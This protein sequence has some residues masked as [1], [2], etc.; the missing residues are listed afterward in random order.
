MSEGTNPRETA[1]PLWAEVDG[2][3]THHLVG[4]DAVGEAI[5]ATNEREGLGFGAVAPSEGKLLELL[6]R[7]HGARKILEVGTHGGYSATWF[8]RSLPDGGSITTLEIDPERAAVARANLERAGFSERV[9]VLVG[10][11]LETLAALHEQGAG[12]YDFVFLD[13]DKQHN[14]EY[15]EWTLKLSAPGTVIV[16]D[17]VIRAGAVIDPEGYDKRLGAGGIQAIRRFYELVAAEPRLRATAVQTV[18]SKGHD[19]FLFAVVVA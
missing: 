14:P 4:E 16:A 10:D 2:Y 15:L 8:A 12:P 7:A 13:A 5:L 3:I 1:D 18:G 11:A 6:A 17:N 9:E 19:G